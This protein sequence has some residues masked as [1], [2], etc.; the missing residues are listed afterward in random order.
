MNLFFLFHF[1][2]KLKFHES[3]K[4]ALA[5]H[6]IGWRFTFVCSNRLEVE[7]GAIWLMFDHKTV[8]LRGMT[9]FAFE[10]YPT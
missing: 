1:E 6:F 2:N 4:I 3:L 8:E 5:F 10:K 7:K 9:R